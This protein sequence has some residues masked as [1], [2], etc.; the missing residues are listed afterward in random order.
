MNWYG[1]ANGL[2]NEFR[3]SSALQQVATAE[4]RTTGTDQ[5][6]RTARHQANEALRLGFDYALA[7]SRAWA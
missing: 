6:G 1:S 2:N 4:G 3:G 7:P 5:T